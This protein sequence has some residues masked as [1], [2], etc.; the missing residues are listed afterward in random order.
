MKVLPVP[1]KQFD[2]NVHGLADHIDMALQHPSGDTETAY[3]NSTSG[4]IH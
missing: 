1:C 3:Q 4:Y 2:I